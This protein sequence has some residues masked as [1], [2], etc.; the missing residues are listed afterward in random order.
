MVIAD[1]AGFG[2][3]ALAGFAGWVNGALLASAAMIG[4]M[5]R[6][7]ASRPPP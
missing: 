7:S 6:V 2:G 3:A 5:L 1:V 4:A